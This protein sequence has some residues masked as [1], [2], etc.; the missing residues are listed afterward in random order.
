M[1]AQKNSIGVKNGEICS[2]KWIFGIVQKKIPSIAT[3]E[4]HARYLLASNAP[5]RVL[6]L[7][8]ALH[9]S[10][11]RVT[12]GKFGSKFE[13]SKKTLIAFPATNLFVALKGQV[14]SC[15]IFQRLF[16]KLRGGS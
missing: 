6:R 7:K 2:D 4:Y 9:T 11:Y 16:S 1:K 5:E 14:S 15:G 10:S 8:F 3:L 12:L 13:F